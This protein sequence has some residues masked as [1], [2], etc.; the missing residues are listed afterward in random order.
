MNSLIQVLISIL[1]VLPFQQGL[2]RLVAFRQ[3]DKLRRIYLGHPDLF[4]IVLMSDV[5][6]KEF[7]FGRNKLTFLIISKNRIHPKTFLS[8]FRRDISS[9]PLSHSFF[10]LEYIPILSE[11]EFQISILRGF[12]IRN[13]MRDVIK[14][15]S[16]LQKQDYVFFIEKQ[17]RF[18]ITHNSFNLLS[19]FLQNHSPNNS[20]F[21]AIKHA[22]RSIRNLAKYYPE[23]FILTNKWEKVCGLLISIPL[24]DFI[25]LPRFRFLT[26]SILLK[27]KS[28]EKRPHKEKY[29]DPIEQ[30]EIFK[31]V[32]RE[33]YIHDVFLTPALIQR[34]HP[35][36]TGKV[37]VDILLNQCVSYK[38]QQT[39]RSKIERLNDSSVKFKVR[40]SSPALF[41][42]AMR[43]SLYPF[44]LEPLFRQKFGL[45]INGLKAEKSVDFD[46]LILACI[47]FFSSQFMHF[48]SLEQKT[49][50]IGSKFIK[51]L[52]LMYR[53]YL[54]NEFLQ[55]NEFN[56]SL[57]PKDIRSCLTPQ[58]NSLPLEQKVTETEWV[59]I[60]A[61]M[62][63]LLKKIRKQLV[64]YDDSLGLLRL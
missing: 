5:E 2:L 58:F 32:S 12:L 63:Y 60:E 29:D 27:Y 41:E 55:G 33:P 31:E 62:K 54:I 24:L 28:K 9:K 18:A 22:R 34:Q 47:H 10:N 57:D 50:L 25:L 3:I 17:N 20:E 13:S 7:L 59:I 30:I 35:T 53:Y 36:W 56:P 51:S 8:Q 1:S 11:R 42:L 52:N 40:F 44:P 26:W 61:Q 38:L 6:K 15:K 49:D 16:L 23:R 37:Y 64:A 45:S 21:S 46:H 14:W 48:R 19:Q 4:D 39:L 43:H